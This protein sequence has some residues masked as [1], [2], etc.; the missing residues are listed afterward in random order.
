MTKGENRHARTDLYTRARADADARTR[1]AREM[2]AHAPRNARSQ[3][4]I[5]SCALLAPTQSVDHS[6]MHTFTL[7]PI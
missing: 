1:H 3:L 7:P 6:R 5:S 2:M 4:K